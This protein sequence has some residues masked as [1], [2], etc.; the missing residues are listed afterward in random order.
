MQLDREVDE[1]LER[2]LNYPGIRPIDI[3]LEIIL[4]STQLPGE[5]HKDPADQMIVAT[6]R[7]LSIPLLTADG[8][9]LQYAHVDLA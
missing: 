7:I 2:A 1:W 8:K 4:E 3:S 6:S 5:F 9:I